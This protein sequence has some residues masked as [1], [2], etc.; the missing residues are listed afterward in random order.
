MYTDPKPWCSTKVDDNGTHIGGQGKW[1]Y[2][3]SKC[4]T[5]K[6]EFKKKILGN[7]DDTIMI[8]KSE[9]KELTNEAEI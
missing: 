2:C 4:P 8:P 1:G 5:E 7:S 9:P 6:G 3:D